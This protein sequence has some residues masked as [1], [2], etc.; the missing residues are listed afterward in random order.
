M[1][2]FQNPVDQRHYLSSS[3]HELVAVR[4]LGAVGVRMSLSQSMSGFWAYSTASKTFVCRSVPRA[5]RQLK[6]N[7]QTDFI[8]GQTE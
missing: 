4:H 1:C 3:P 5:V 7:E 8:A 2:C 6:I